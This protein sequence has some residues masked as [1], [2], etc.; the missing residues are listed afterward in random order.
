MLPHE[1]V[2]SLLRCDETTMVRE[3]EFD[4][5]GKNVLKDLVYRKRLKKHETID[6]IVCYYDLEGKTRR[7]LTKYLERRTSRR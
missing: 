5:R 1:F 3:E 7:Y 2:N 6:G 4:K